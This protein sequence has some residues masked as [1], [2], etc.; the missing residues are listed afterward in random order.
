MKTT[1]FIVSLILKFGEIWKKDQLMEYLC[2][3][4]WGEKQLMAKGVFV[5]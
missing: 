3:K 5:C 2:G 4:T 1:I